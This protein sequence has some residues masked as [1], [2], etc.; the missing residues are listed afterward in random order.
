MIIRPNHI[1]PDPDH[2]LLLAIEGVA[3]GTSV[4]SSTIQSE[5][6]LVKAYSSGI[7]TLAIALQADGG[8]GTDTEARAYASGI[9]TLTYYL[10]ANGGSEDAGVRAYASGI[11]TL[12]IH[13]QSR[14]TVVESSVSG[15]NANLVNTQN[16]VTTVEAD[17]VVDKAYSSGIGTLASI[18][19]SNRLGGLY[20]AIAL[21]QDQQVSGTNGGTFSSGTWVTRVLNTEV[22][23]PYNIA[24]LSANRI[25]LYPGTYF[26][27]ARAPAYN[28]SSNQLRIKNKTNDA[29]L[30]TGQSNFSLSPT[31]VMNMALLDG[32]TGA[33]SGIN[34]LE[35]QHRC[36]ATAATFG[37]GVS[38]SYGTETYAQV[39][40]YK[41]NV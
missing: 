29:T 26:I 6:T 34:V 5:V 16:R 17:A 31:G 22:Y 25:T 37:L 10:Q 2:K 41:E 7:G 23:D 14:V 3:S 11:N 27:E 20:T 12:A 18:I 1:L 35:L 19:Q 9:G 32:T 28:C 38:N 15:I 33:L 4:L 36:T 8:S 39:K 21:Y 13:T 24:T 30:I 40:I